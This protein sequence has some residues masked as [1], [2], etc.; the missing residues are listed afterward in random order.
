MGGNRG[1]Y[2]VST[3]KKVNITEIRYLTKEEKKAKYFG[4]SFD[5]LDISAT[6]MK[7]QGME[8]Y[9]DSDKIYIYVDFDNEI[10]KIE[11]EII[12]SSVLDDDKG[13]EYRVLLNYKA[14]R[15]EHA[16]FAFINKQQGNELKQRSLDAYD[17]GDS[18]SIED[19]VEREERRNRI[20]MVTILPI[21]GLVTSLILL[22][23]IVA[24]MF[25]ARPIA[26]DIISNYFDV[27]YSF[28]WNMALLGLA[29]KLSGV[30]FVISGL[31]FLINYAYTRR[32]KD[33]HNRVLMIVVVIAIA[34]VAL[35]STF[36][37]TRPY[38]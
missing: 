1:F 31:S 30:L 34:L 7:I 22:S 28:E 15:I 27:P 2:R 9:N 23:C 3:N 29:Y 32:R 10:Q 25:M 36:I 17:H 14:R 21:V 24:I 5:L 4:E 6:G 35:Q 20:G 13:Y 16:I 11:G 8:K 12:G 19:K 37:F 38:P 18:R 33:R 26:T